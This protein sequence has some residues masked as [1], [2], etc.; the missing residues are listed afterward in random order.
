MGNAPPK[1]VNFEDVQQKGA[2]LLI[3]VLDN[4]DQSVL[5]A[6]TVQSSDEVVAVEDALRRK[7]PI[8]VYGRHASDA[9]ALAKCAQLHALGSRPYLYA[10][11]LFEWLLLQDVFGAELFPTTGNTIDLL[12]YKAPATFKLYLTN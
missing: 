7:I 3:S 6:N 12:R 1:Q 9:A 10:G 8:I 4:S 5:I 2:A 11:G